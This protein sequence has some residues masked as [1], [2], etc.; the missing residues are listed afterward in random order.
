MRYR[1]LLSATPYRNTNNL[2]YR[3]R[4]EIFEPRKTSN[5]KLHAL[6][7]LPISL[8]LKLM[9]LAELPDPASTAALQSAS[10]PA[11]AI[12]NDLVAQLVRSHRDLTLPTIAG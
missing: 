5:E 6:S 11:S 3:K 4:E 7:N 9:A 8:L 12:S 10:R 2:L 1:L